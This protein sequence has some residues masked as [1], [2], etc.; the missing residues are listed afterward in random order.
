MKKTTRLCKLEGKICF[1]S[2][3]AHEEKKV[4]T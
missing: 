2:V 1:T 4:G 3:L